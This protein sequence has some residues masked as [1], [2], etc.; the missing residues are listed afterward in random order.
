MASWHRRDIWRGSRGRSPCI[1]PGQAARGRQAPCLRGTHLPSSQLGTLPAV[2]LR[3]AS[4]IP[5]GTR[6]CWLPGLRT[7][8]YRQLGGAAAQLG[9]ARAGQWLRK[10]VEGSEVV[11][12]T[13]LPCTPHP[14]CA[15]LPLLNP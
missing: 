7:Q 14:P 1:W 11:R 13:V 12:A 3:L 8:A 9:S 10:V 6:P 2:A 15:T 4:L 5:S